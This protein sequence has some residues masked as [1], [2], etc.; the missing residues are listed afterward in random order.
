[1]QFSA[2]RYFTKE[3]DGKK[4]KIS[5]VPGEKRGPKEENATAFIY[6]RVLQDNEK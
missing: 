2:M 4:V 5:V 3:I 1:V 6:F